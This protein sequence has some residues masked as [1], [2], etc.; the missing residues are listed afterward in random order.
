MRDPYNLAE[1]GILWD[2]PGAKSE[3]PDKQIIFKVRKAAP[4]S[5]SPRRGSGGPVPEHVIN[6]AVA[7]LYSSLVEHGS[8]ERAELRQLKREVGDLRKRLTKIE[9]QF[10]TEEAFDRE[11]AREIK[12]IGAGSSRP[13]GICPEDWLPDADELDRLLE[14]D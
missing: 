1:L 3:S 14:E 5:L 10:A 6:D 13:S 11:I 9:S 2:K 4:K 12:A 7:K 8:R